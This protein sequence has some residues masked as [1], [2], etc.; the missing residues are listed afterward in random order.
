MNKPA[1]VVLQFDRVGYA[2]WRSLA[3]KGRREDYL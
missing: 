3:D 2:L 1:R